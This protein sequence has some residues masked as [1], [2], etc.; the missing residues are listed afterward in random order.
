MFRRIGFDCKY[1]DRNPIV[2]TKYMLITTIVNNIDIYERG[3]KKSLSEQAFS[4]YELKVINNTSNQYKS[5]YDAYKPV[6]DE[7]AYS[8]D[9]MFFCHP[10]IY[11]ETT[12]ELGRLVDCVTSIFFS[13]HSNIG[14]IGVAGASLGAVYE[15]YSTITHG[16]NKTKF[17]CSIFE[18]KDYVLCQ[19]IDACAYFVRS[20]I[21]RKIPFNKNNN[22]FHLLIEEYSLRLRMDGINTAVIPANIWHFSQGASL[23]YNYY[24]EM[25]HVAAMHKECKY[26]NTTSFQWKNDIILPFKL[27]YYS[28]RN[29]I[30]HILFN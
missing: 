7:K 1:A 22:S 26:I 18:D 17:Q 27:T 23:D 8:S 20:D 14:V 24:R 11:F 3:L 9:V 21:L 28:F 19:T 30:H 13:D 16:D 6:L 15:I 29:Y 5:L 10:D 25:K 2:R 12:D 4:A